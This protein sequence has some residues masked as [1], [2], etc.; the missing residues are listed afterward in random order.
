MN[1]NKFL[2]LFGKD[3]LFSAYDYRKELPPVANIT[4]IKELRELNKQGYCIFFAV[5]S[6][7]DNKRNNKN[8]KAIRAIWIDDDNPRPSP[9]TDFPLKPSIIVAT[10]KGKYQYYWL[11]ST[12]NFDEFSLVMQTMVDKHGNDAGVKD[13]AR[14]LRLPGYY[15]M[16]DRGNP[17]RV[18]VVGGTFEP[19]DWEM[20]TTA[21]PPAKEIKSSTKVKGKY[22]KKKACKSIE[23]GEDYHCS[24][25]DRAMELANKKLD[26]EEIV[27]LLKVDMLQVP[28]ADRDKRWENRNSDTHLYECAESAVVKY[29][30]ERVLE[31]NIDQTGAEN[32]FIQMHKLPDEILSPDDLYGELVKSLLS[33]Q[34]IPNIMA[35]HIAADGIIAERAGGK[36]SGIADDDRMNINECAVGTSG[37]GKGIVIN[38]PKV[39][40]NY[41]A[42]AGM[43]CGM[44]I[45]TKLGSKQAIEEEFILNKGKPD[46]LFCWDEFG[47]AMIEASKDANSEVAKILDDALTYY[48]ESHTT[49]TERSLAKNAGKD[50]RK[51]HAPHLN[52]IGTATEHSLINGMNISN[53]REGQAARNL[54]FPT[55]PYKSKPVKDKDRKKLNLSDELKDNLIKLSLPIDIPVGAHYD[56][57]SFRVLAPVRVNFDDEASEYLYQVGV[58][59]QNLPRGSLIADLKNR[60]ELNTKKKAMIRALVNN[61]KNPVVTL[62]IAKWAFSI[63]DYSDK[64][65]VK[66]FE[67]GVSESAFDK[68]VLA[69]KKSL[70]NAHPRWL[71]QSN[72]LSN[73]NALRK[74]GTRSMKMDL[75][76]HIVEDLDGFER[77]ETE[78]VRGKNGFVY[79]SLKK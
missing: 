68:A 12:T 23:A 67:D 72:L 34:K 24:L 4:D 31:K 18:R 61:P 41:L 36:Y 43:P 30:S 28:E 55:T 25:R 78:S 47:K 33:T 32:D 26:A 37:D 62:D 29:E 13:L 16:K 3:H 21:F 6:M 69:V 9:R 5:N 14:V 49:H 51:F 15:H 79:R 56:I 59:V 45:I 50:K 58:D 40:S 10:S 2:Q 54:F 60:T 70:K 1:K 11:T 65:K 27:A 53:A 42:L 52:I 46:I 48:S 19:Y 75:L 7:R 17:Q 44:I 20:I 8:T 66:M 77:K 22:N 57:E 38:G 76:K 39:V 71:K 74:L 73:I 35:C 63:V 64:Y